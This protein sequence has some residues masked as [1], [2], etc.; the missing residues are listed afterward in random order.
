MENNREVVLVPL[1][2]T[3][4]VGAA[5]LKFLPPLVQKFTATL[6]RIVDEA[7]E[8]TNALTDERLRLTNEARNIRRDIRAAVRNGLN[9]VEK[10]DEFATIVLQRNNVTQIQLGVR[11]LNYSLLTELLW[12]ISVCLNR[13][14][15]IHGAFQEHCNSASGLCTSL[16]EASSS[17]ACRA[18]NRRR[19]TQIGGGI[20]SGL[21]LVGSVGVAVGG[22]IT[23]I[24]AGVF[25]GGAGAAIGLPLTAAATVALAGTGTAGAVATAISAERYEQI[26]CRFSQLSNSLISMGNISDDLVEHINNLNTAL[27]NRQETSDEITHWLEHDG[28]AHTEAICSALDRLVEL[29]CSTQDSTS[30]CRE[31]LRNL[32]Y[33]LQQLD[34]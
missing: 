16:V 21:A 14:T 31:M 25:T 29:C 24:I 18:R 17:N 12:Q 15:V 30:P 3:T 23:S 26:A 27:T 34:L 8:G 11:T 28:H 4:E 32:R 7:L 9:F 6:Q 1:L 33:R 20:G 10:I 22:T 2:F 5:L 13:A 19:S